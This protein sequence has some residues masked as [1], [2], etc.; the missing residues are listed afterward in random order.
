M[1]K[2]CDVCASFVFICRNYTQIQT[3]PLFLLTS[4]LNWSPCPTLSVCVNVYVQ[5]LVSLL[6]INFR[7]KILVL[8][9]HLSVTLEK[10]F[11]KGG[12][13]TY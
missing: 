9:L 1:C 10:K 12:E 5:I 2:Y 8:I 3:H 7:L 13:N 6:I 11:T 4:S